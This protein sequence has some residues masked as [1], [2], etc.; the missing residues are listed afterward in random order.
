MGAVL[1]T[2][3]L[4]W[5]VLEDPSLSGAQRAILDGASAEDPVLVADITLWEIANLTLLGRLELDLPLGDWLERATAPPLVRVQPITSAIAAEVAALPRG[6]TRDP[7]DRL[8]VATARVLGSTL[9]TR[10]GRIVRAG[11]VPTVA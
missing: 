2:H 1:D 4:V 7:A 9:L 6:F 11:V 3:V 10:D 5:W 8:I